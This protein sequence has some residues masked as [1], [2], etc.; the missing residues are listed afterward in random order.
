MPAVF[1]YVRDGLG[2]AANAAPDPVPSEA[3]ERLESPVPIDAAGVRARGE[4]R[5]AAEPAVRC[6]EDGPDRGLIG[7]FAPDAADRIARERL[8]RLRKPR[9]AA[10]HRR[11]SF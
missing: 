6:G 4:K 11:R 7:E 3:V 10:Q 1:L 5:Q 8:D 9:G 2:I